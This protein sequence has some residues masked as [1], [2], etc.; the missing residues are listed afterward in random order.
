MGE[1][2]VAVGTPYPLRIR[3]G[4]R[5]EHAPAGSTEIRSAGERDG[6]RDDMAY[7]LHLVAEN[8]PRLVETVNLGVE[9]DRRVEVEKIV[10]SVGRVLHLA[11]CL[12]VPL[13]AYLTGIHTVVD[14]NLR[15]Y[16][17]VLE[18]AERGRHRYVVLNAVAPVLDEA[19]LEKLVLLCRQR[20]LELSGVRHPYLLVPAFASYG[21]LALERSKLRHGYSKVWETDR[22]RLVLVALCD[23]GRGR[24]A[25]LGIR[26]AVGHVDR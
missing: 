8:L 3:I 25:P 10:E 20:I 14:G 24:H 21:A 9:R 17:D 12:R 16:V 2:V 22:Q 11:R 1:I 7:H 4:I 18:E 19:F 15:R 5:P 6:W 23:V 13:T 26:D